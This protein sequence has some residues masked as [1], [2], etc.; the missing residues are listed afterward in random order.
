MARI[1]INGV[2]VDPLTQQP[3]L[4]AASL[5]SADAS[6][7]NY[8]LVQ[9]KQPLD[10]TEKDDLAKRGVRILEYVP[11]HTYLCHYPP[12][13]LAAIRALPYVSW[14]NTY[15]EGFKVAPTLFAAPRGPQAPN[16]LEMAAAP[17]PLMDRTPKTVDVV[18][19][20]NV[21]PDSV[22]DKLAAAARLDPADLKLSAHK[23]RIT[24]Q[25]R[26]LSDLA[27]IDEVRHVEEVIPLKLHNNVARQI[28]RVGLPLA[29]PGVVFEG[30]GQIVAVADTGFDKGSRTNVHPAFIG[31]VQKLY[32][33]G[34]PGKANDPA[35]HGTHV[36][37]SVLGDGN[38][39]A[40]GGAIRGTAPKARLVLQSVLDSS[41]GLG[42]LPAD[43][44]DL[45]EAPYRDDNAR[46]HTNSWGSQLGD[47]RYDQNAR[48]LDDFVW[49]HR[50]CLICFSAGNEGVDSQGSG[51]VDPQSISPPGTA[52]NCLTVGASENNRPTIP[53]RYGDIR[54]DRFPANPI[55]GDRMADNPEGVAAFSSRGP[56]RDQRIKP[57]V[58]APGTAILSTLSR[59]VEVP[60]HVF[61]TS[62]DGLFFFDAG[63]S[64][65]TPLV[66]GCVAVVREF[67]Q[68]EQHI[69]TPSAALI[70][71]LMINGARDVAGQYVLTEAG[72]I[73]NSAEGFGRVD[74]AAVIGPLAANEALNFQDEGNALDTNEEDAIHVT[75]RP[76]MSALKVTL[77]W[78]DPPGETL[79]NDLDLIVRAADGQERHGNVGSSSSDFDRSNNVEQVVWQNAPPGD[80]TITVR[81]HRVAQF[82]QTYAL[83]VR[84]T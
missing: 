51:R 70:K 4:A 76:N 47:G 82:P 37:G 12:T 13:D 48:E 45:F 15:M 57:D 49:N 19:H 61:G 50:D 46:I 80:L 11:D 16:L 25:G 26:Y 32:A 24:V 18:F 66:A 29:G 77:V 43:L 69:S 65:A 59:D 36:A 31:R 78:T 56:T 8:I 73:P 6:Q 35:G 74:L 79:Q 21:A 58:V 60:S 17:K 1:T 44:H 52:K 53:V 55:A 10:K 42:G 28:L 64:M 30:D 41:G 27:A 71:A 3:I 67:L 2:T 75:I 9:T 83:V 72:V 22:R 34:R 14:A 39:A 33:L 81:A 5:E 40:M 84:T 20:A 38:S 54:P 63:T 62:T 23:A 68:K 7:S